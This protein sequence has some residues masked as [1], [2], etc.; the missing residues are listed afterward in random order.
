VRWVGLADPPHSPLHIIGV[1]RAVK[2]SVP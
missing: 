2:K 1:V